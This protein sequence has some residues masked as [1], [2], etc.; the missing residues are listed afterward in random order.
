[1]GKKEKAKA[2]RMVGHPYGPTP[3]A[4]LNELTQNSGST[5][6]VDMMDL[7]GEQR[8]RS[9]ESD[10]RAYFVCQALVDQQCSMKC[11]APVLFSG[12]KWCDYH[13]QVSLL[14]VRLRKF[15]RNGSH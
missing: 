13:T 12:T 6:D 8:S 1:M 4:M 11:E 7:D 10:A 3:G 2:A 5:L 14:Y 15:E 9:A